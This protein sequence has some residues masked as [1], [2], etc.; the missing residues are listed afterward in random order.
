MVES[1]PKGYKPWLIASL[2]V[3][4][5]SLMLLAGTVT[6]AFIYFGETKTPLWIVAMGVIAVF[7]VLVGFG[8]LFMLMAAAGIT[9]F[10]EGRRVQVISPQHHD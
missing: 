9:S 5:G 4:V 1:I 10:R 2:A 6:G 3:L 7:G 8:G